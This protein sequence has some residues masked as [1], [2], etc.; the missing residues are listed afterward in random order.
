MKYDHGL[1][2]FRRDLRIE[3]NKSLN[4][5]H[6]LC[7]HVHVTFIF[8]PEQITE[9]NT[10][11]SN[12]AV[13]FMLQCISELSDNISEREGHLSLHYGS[14]KL[15]I[16]E[17]I[18]KLSIDCVFF[19]EDITP[20]AKK[21]DKEIYDL[22]QE[23]N[24]PCRTGQDY[25]LLHPLLFNE[26]TERGDI[27]QKFTPFYDKAVKTKIDKPRVMRKYKFSSFGGVNAYITSVAKIRKKYTYPNPQIVSSGGRFN[28]LDTLD[29]A[30]KR[31]RDYGSTRDILYCNT[32]MLSAY[33]KFGCVS[34]REVY[35]RLAD[36]FGKKS[37]IIRQLFWRE[38]YMF[39]LFHFPEVYEGSFNEKYNSLKWSSSEKSFNDWK[40]GETGFPVVDACMHELNNTGYMHNR[41]RLIVASFLVK[42]LL[43]DWRKGEKYF[44]RQLV[45][46][47]PAS[48]NGNWQ[49]IAGGGANSQPYFRVFNP[50]LQSE[51]FDKD[52]IYIKKWIPELKNIEPVHIHQWYKYHTEYDVYRKPIVDYNEQKEKSLYMYKAIF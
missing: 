36:A 44:A 33:I 22:C 2:I 11:L 42:T 35:H 37:E 15:I 45:D 12:N 23:E 7:N 31:L 34:I 25:Y 5:A 52:C 39:V 26:R 47:D 29:S 9:K 21:R 19:N 49:W 50:W 32:S 41:G 40:N 43:I 13:L 8:T 24:I 16:K 3:D 20:Y 38:F 27:F 6:E 17:L 18:D 28:G 10:F 51:Q 4:E 14:N 48:N 1:F 46:Y 30:L